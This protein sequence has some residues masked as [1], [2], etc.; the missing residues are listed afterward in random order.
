[1]PG[2]LNI[3]AA[4][5]LSTTYSTTGYY[6]DGTKVVGTQGSAITFTAATSNVATE[7][8]NISNAI[9]SILTALRTHGLIAT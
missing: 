4:N 1:M 3:G 5:T 9:T 7:I 8:T 6:V 2:N